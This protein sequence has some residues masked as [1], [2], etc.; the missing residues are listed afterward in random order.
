M[1]IYVD[2][3]GLKKLGKQFLDALPTANA[4]EAEAGWKCFVLAWL[5]CEYSRPGEEIQGE[6]LLRIMS[7]YKLEHDWKMEVL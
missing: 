3:D 2:F 7:R 4:E 5:N 1:S 6:A